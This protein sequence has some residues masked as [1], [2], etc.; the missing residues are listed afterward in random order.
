MVKSWIVI[1]LIWVQFPVVTPKLFITE[2]MMQRYKDTLVAKGSALYNALQN[3]DAKLAEAVYKETTA[4][5]AKMHSKE[6]REWFL[7][8]SRK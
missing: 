2:Y 4:N 7:E 1:P 6:D 8:Q 5:Y 3:K